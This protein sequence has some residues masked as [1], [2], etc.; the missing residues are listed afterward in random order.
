MRVKIAL[1]QLTRRIAKL[2]RIA[3]MQATSNLQQQ[4]AAL[5]DEQLELLL[6]RA[7]KADRLI[8]EGKIKFD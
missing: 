7:R 6:E 5:S 1:K 8:R 3:G 2:E 4:L